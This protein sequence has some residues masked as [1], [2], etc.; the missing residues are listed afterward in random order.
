MGDA[1]VPN[2]NMFRD[3]CVAT[4]LCFLIECAEGYLVL[5]WP[6]NTVFSDK[7]VV[8]HLICAQGAM[9]HGLVCACIYD[10]TI[11]NKNAPPVFFGTSLLASVLWSGFLVWNM[12]KL[13]RSPS[14]RGLLVDGGD[15]TFLGYVYAAF[16]PLS[17]M[18]VYAAWFWFSRRANKTTA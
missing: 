1:P 16:T 13:G 15:I 18:T 10:I 4:L 14:P 11:R 5:G 9:V 17:F 12:S 8:L 7:G 2:S 6:L 3:W